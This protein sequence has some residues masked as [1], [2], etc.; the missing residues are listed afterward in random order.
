[1]DGL[2]DS[3]QGF[4]FYKNPFFHTNDSIILKKRQ[5]C[6]KGMALSKMSV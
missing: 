3:S 5:L 1:M 6:R 4:L 2:R